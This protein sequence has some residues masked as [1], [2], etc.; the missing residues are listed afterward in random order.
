MIYYTAK[1]HKIFNTEKL[2]N[3]II[4][5]FTGLAENGVLI[6]INGEEFEVFFAC[7]LFIGN[8]NETKAFNE[9]NNDGE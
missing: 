9:R 3:N 2:Y 1:Y 7:G 4:D 8:S 6:N 5:I